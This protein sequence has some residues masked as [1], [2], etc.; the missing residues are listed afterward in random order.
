MKFFSREFGHSYETY[1]FG[2][3]NFA[4]KEDSDLLSEIYKRGYLPYSGNTA[5]RDTFY[6][7]R[8]ARIPLLDFEPTSENRRIAKKHD[9]VFEKKRIPFEE[10]NLH[11]ETFLTFCLTYFKTRHGDSM[12]E[13][14][15]KFILSLN[16]ISHIVIYKKGESIV[17]YVFEVSDEQM[18][19]FW[20]SFYDL[21]YLRQ[22]LGLWLMLDS[23]RDAKNAGLEHFYLGTAYGEKGLYKTNFEP[24]EFWDGEIWNP[25]VRTLK[26]LCK[27]D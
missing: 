26:Q 1:S 12:P 14:R 10:F 20:Y 5:I 19:H 21:V 3:C 11:D 25:D 17:A 9:G 22:S 8:S 27:Q 4:G 7:A 18:T 16:L 6:M 24:L 2:Y 15:L 23:M 13:E